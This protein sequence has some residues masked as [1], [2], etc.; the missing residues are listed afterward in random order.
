VTFPRDLPCHN[1]RDNEYSGYGADAVGDG[2][3]LRKK[4]I[5]VRRDAQCRSGDGQGAAGTGHKRSGRRGGW[6]DAP[7][8]QQ[9]GRPRRRDAGQRVSDRT[10]HVLFY[11][12]SECAGGKKRD[13]RPSM[14]KVTT[15]VSI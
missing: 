1:G 14:A 11:H 5:E 4:Q 6:P 10:G 3:M 15:T 12:R 7:P 9:V 13:L 8:R 2:A